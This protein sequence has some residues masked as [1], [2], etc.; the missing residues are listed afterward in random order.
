MAVPR[1]HSPYWGASE[2]PVRVDDVDRETWLRAARRTE[3]ELWALAE[4]NRTPAPTPS[5]PATPSGDSA[6]AVAEPPP[7]PVRPAPAP[8]LA[9]GS[10]P[11][12]GGDP[13][14]RYVRR[15]LAPPRA[16]VLA[17]LQQRP[18]A[19]ATCR[20]M[21]RRLHFKKAEL[22]AVLDDLERA[23]LGRLHLQRWRPP[24]APRYYE[25]LAFTL[26]AAGRDPAVLLL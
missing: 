18:G 6:G 25:A 13:A 26:T 17:F 23:G 10:C 21:M 24:W 15:P 12:C 2:R 7:R 9:R 14:P 16:R 11:H 22:L 3:T 5:L 1:F 8:P 4:S 19:S 20:T